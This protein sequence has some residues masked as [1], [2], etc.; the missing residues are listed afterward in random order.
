MITQDKL[1][2]KKF[3]KLGVLVALSIPM[4]AFS[5]QKTLVIP[6]EPMLDQMGRR[7]VEGF[8]GVGSSTQPLPASPQFINPQ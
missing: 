7:V 6:L 1:F 5:A 2:R 4:L 8:F 3:G